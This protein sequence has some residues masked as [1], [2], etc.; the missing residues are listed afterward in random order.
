M[1][2]VFRRWG[3]RISLANKL[4]IGFLLIW[5]VVLCHRLIWYGG[6]SNGRCEAQ[7]GI[8]AYF[9]NL[10]DA[11]MTC[12]FPMVTLTALGILIGRSVHRVVQRGRVAPATTNNESTHCRQP[13]I[14][15]MDAQLTIM[16]FLDIFVAM[17]SF[18][19]YAAHLIYINVTDT[20]SKSPLR[21]A[22]E[23]IIIEIIRLL[24]YIFFSCSF[25]VS[26][27]SL[28]GFRNQ[29]LRAIY[30]K[31]PKKST[32]TGTGMATKTAQTVTNGCIQSTH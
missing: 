11:I 19:P 31:E 21:V 18:L 9:D 17:I 32:H 20:W 22:W 12:L 30:L 7:P 23:T 16:L 4:V 13:A 29:L 25:Y 5:L 14:Q 24:S 1:R 15:K 10:F 28:T 6:A 2:T 3:N 27:T 8:Y 26:I